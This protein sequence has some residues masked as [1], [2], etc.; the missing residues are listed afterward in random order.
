MKYIDTLG[1]TGRQNK[2]PD[3]AVP[4]VTPSLMSNMGYITL[5]TSN[6]KYM[7]IFSDQSLAAFS[8]G[9]GIDHSIEYIVAVNGWVLATTMHLSM[10]CVNVQSDVSN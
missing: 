7:Y 10:V 3:I 1:Q 5:T 9:H 4:I 6:M 2:R 8:T